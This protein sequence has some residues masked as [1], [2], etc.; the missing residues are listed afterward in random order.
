MG[1]SSSGQWI[2]FILPDRRVS[3]VDWG[4]SKSNMSKIVSIGS[5]CFCGTSL[6]SFKRRFCNCFF[7]YSTFPTGHVILIY[8]KVIFSPDLKLFLGTNVVFRSLFCFGSSLSLNST[9]DNMPIFTN[10]S[11]SL[12][13][14]SIAANGTFRF[15][16]K[17]GQVFSFSSNFAII[18]V[19]LPRPA[20]N[21]SGKLPFSSI[22][23]FSASAVM[24][25]TF[26]AKRIN[27][28]IHEIKFLKPVRTQQIFCV[29]QYEDLIFFV[30]PFSDTGIIILP[31]NFILYPVKL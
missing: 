25:S 10:R 9:F 11:S 5:S 6:E 15:F 19:H 16:L 26:F 27:W 1:R 3:S 21:T 20:E 14:S 13:I 18:L 17:M 24:H 31:S 30:I 23:I 12:F 29:L 7:N 4:G 8:F 2:S 22:L 28:L